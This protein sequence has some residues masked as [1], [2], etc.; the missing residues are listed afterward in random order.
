VNQA[1]ALTAAQSAL[2][3][4]LPATLQAPTADGAIYQP[5]GAA[6]GSW[7]TLTLSQFTVGNPA[8]PASAA[9]CYGG[10]PDLSSCAYISARLSLDYT[11]HF[12]GATMRIPGFVTDTQVLDTYDTQTQ[13]Y[14]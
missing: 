4:A 9:L 2:P 14:R 7:G 10:S 1:A 13:T 6:P 5:T 3:L 11:V 8:Q 12:L